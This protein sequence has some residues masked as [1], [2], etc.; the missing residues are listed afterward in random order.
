MAAPVCTLLVDAGSGKVMER[1][2]A[3]CDTRNS[4]AS[5]FKVAIAVMGYD[6]GILTGPHAP[7]WPYKAEY[8]AWMDSWKTTV[9]PTSWLRDSVVWYSRQVTQRLG[10]GGFQR[11]VDRLAYGN[12]DV[13]GDPGKHNGLTS[14]WL[15]SSLQISPAEQVAFLRKLLSRQLPVSGAAQD[16]TL[17]I[18]PRY[19]LAN[20]WT[21][22]GKTG[23]G[24]QTDA[25]G[26]IERDRQFGWFVGWAQKGERRIVFAR[27][28]KDAGRH[29][30]NAGPRTRDSILA[31]LPLLL[32]DR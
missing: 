12:R 7:A 15:S 16:R 3:Q 2:G 10:P 29:K 31:D 28:I 1:Q 9:D 20:G 13:S 8:Q 11:G 18:M 5:T 23:T 32:P 4:P 26:A 22:Y 30:D 19:P 27:L 21:V 25:A 6:A 14:A 24:F 17:A